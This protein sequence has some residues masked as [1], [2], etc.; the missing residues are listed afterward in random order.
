MR[1]L[2][3]KKR[4]GGQRDVEDGKCSQGAHGGQGGFISAWV[5]FVRELMDTP[6]LTA[7]GYERIV[8][9][10]SEPVAQAMIAHRL[11]CTVPSSGQWI[12]ICAALTRS[13][14]CWHSSPAQHKQVDVDMSNAF[15]MAGASMCSDAAFQAKSKIRTT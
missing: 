1:M 10:R 9:W 3:F 12:G 5:L 2:L 8:I 15:G 7:Q 11:Y 6:S 4:G 14:A 13:S